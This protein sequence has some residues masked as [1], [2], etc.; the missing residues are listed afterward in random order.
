MQYKFKLLKMHCAACAMALE[1]NINTMEGVT[2]KISYVTKL[3]EL[4]IETENPSETLTEVKVAIHNF[5]HMVEI[6]DFEDEN[7]VE[8][9]EKRHI[10][11]NAARFS[12]VAVL[13]ILNIFMPIKWLQITFFA[14]LYVVAA[15]DVVISA[16]L[17]S[18][19]A[20]FL[21]NAF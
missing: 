18:F 19:M 16:F 6:V 13:L 7:D 1:E 5:D 10:I 8:R 3:L 20:R 4:N 14:L 15:Y 2:A 9:K 21:M 12:A 11:F 17:T